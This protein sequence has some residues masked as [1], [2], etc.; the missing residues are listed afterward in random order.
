[1]VL[2]VISSQAI[3]LGIGWEIALISTFGEQNLAT[4]LL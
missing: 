1:M 3:H 4:A 2:I